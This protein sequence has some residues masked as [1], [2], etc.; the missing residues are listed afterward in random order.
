ML[1]STVVSVGVALTVGLLPQFT[2]QAVAED[3][4]LSRPATQ[5]SLDDPVDGKN[6][7]ARKWDRND[8][9]E[10]AKVTKADRVNWPKAGK[11]DL[12]L[13]GKPVQAEGLPVKVAKADRTSK[14]G[15]NGSTPSSVE[16]EVLG[17]EKAEKAH[18]DGTL[19][20]VGRSDGSGEA[21]PVK[22]T[23]D[24]SSFADAYGGS[25]GSRLRLVEYPE[26]VLTTPDKKK[27]STPKPL[28]TDNDAEDRT[29]TAVV[30]A[31]A[32]TTGEKEDA[33]AQPRTLSQKSNATG[34][35]FTV[36]AA[37]AGESGG[38]GDYKATSLQ[39]S[40]QWSVSNSSGAFNWSYPITAPPVPGGLA[41][42]VSFGYGSQ[43]IDGQTA[44]TNNQGSWVGQGFSYEPGYIERRYK[45]CSE[46]GHAETNGD[47]CWA[48][49]NAT[50][51][52]AGGA[53]GELIKDDTTG[54]WRVSSD[55]FSKVERLTGATNGDNNGEYWKITAVNGTQYFFGLNQLPGFASG[56]TET[57]S[58]WTV[59]VY[60]DDSGE[61]CYDANLADAHCRQAWR[62]NLDYVVD[63]NGS[64][65]AYY[66]GKETNYYTQGLK[67]DENGKAYTRGGY[68][69]RI[70]YGLR[71]DS[72]YDTQPSARIVFTAAERCIGDLTDCG[73]DELTDSTAADWPDVPWDRNC[74]VDTKCPGQNSPTFWTRKKLTKITTQVRD[75]ATTFK[76]V[77]SWTLGHVFSD[78]G[79]GSKSLW[80]NKIVHTGH[81][82]SDETVP[83]IELGGIQL[84]NRIDKTGDNIQP[85]NRFRLNSVVSESGSHLTVNYAD[86]QCSEKN[87]PAAERSTVR[88][89]PVKWN[90]PGEDDPITDWFHKYVVSQVI[91]TDLV[92]GS[93]KQ[94]SS[95]TYLG[96]AG[97]RKAKDD[98]LSK[99]EY[100]TW[101]DWR[102]YQR[103]RVEK[104]DGT[105]K[106]SNT[107]TE[108][109]FF[110]GLDGDKNPDGTE[111][112]STL[113][114]S[115]GQTYTDSDW[116][117]GF[118]AET[119]TYNGSTVVSKS[120]T[121]AWNKVTATRAKSWGTR[122][123][124]FLK[125]LRTDTYTALPGG[126]WR[127]TASTTTYD[128]K[129]G[130]VT[131]VADH[132]ELGVADN[133]CTT[134]EYA[135]NPDKHMYSFVARVEVLGVG[136]DTTPDRS[137]QVI[138]DD[139]TLY[140]GTTDVGAAP[141]KGHPTTIK[142]LASH[143]GSAAT[144]QTVTQAT[145]DTY[146]RPLTVKDAAGTT[147]TTTYTETNGLAT[148]KTDKNP[149]GWETTT[150]Y[151]PEWGSPTG[152]VDP[153]GKRTDLAYD[154]FGR[155]TSVWLPDRPK[156][157]Y[158][159][160]IK[161]SYGIRRDGPNYVHTEKV[162][163]DGKSY[164]SEY[165][166]YDGLL[167][168]RQIQTEGAGGNR[169]IAD[170]LYDGVGRT[171]TTN[172]TYA[173]T[174]APSTDLFLPE[175]KDL[176]AQTVTVYDGAGRTTA[177][178]LNVAGAEKYRTTYA[179]EGDRVH[180]DPPTGQTPTT[181]IVDAH[182]R[183]VELRQYDKSTSP[184]PTG[185]ETDYL[186]TTYTY[187]PSGQLSVVKDD[188][189]NTWSY[190]YDQRGR[191]KEA[192][193][194]DTGKSTFEYDA[195]DRMTSVKDSRGKTT[196][197]TYDAIGRKTGTWDGPAE[198]GT[199][200]SV[201]KWDS[202]AKGHL[203]AEYTYKNNAVYSS[204]LY[205]ALD[206]TYQ[207][208]LVKYNLS[209]TAEPKLGGA[210][211]FTTQYNAD[212]SV[213]SQSFPAT[214][215]LSAETIRYQYD[216]I[217]RPV[218]LTTSLSGGSY[219]TGTTYSPTSQLEQMQLSL[220]GTNKKTWLSYEYEQGTDRLTRSSVIVEGAT[221]AA[222]EGAYTYDQAGNVRSIVD[223]P[224]GGT[225]D[226]QC[227]THD[228][229]RQ[230]TSAWT[231]KVTPD[232]KVGT[233]APDAACAAEPSASN[234]GGTAAYWS[235]YTYDSIGNRKTQ[236]RHGL[237]G[238]PTRET[239]YVYGED[240]AGP[241]QLTTAVTKTA[242][243]STTPEVVS[244]NTYDYDT[245]G[246]TTHR[247]LDGDTQTLTW[248]NQGDLTTVKEANGSETAYVYDSAGS[249]IVRETPT[250]K[251]FYLPGMELKLTKSS[252]TVEAQRFYSF[253]GQ[254]IA[255][256]DKSGVTFL[257][258]DH[259]GT[260]QIAVKA[261]TGET[262]RRR[263][264]PF[265]EN[266]DQ[267][268]TGQS[269]WPTD[270]GFV[271]GTNDKTTG[272]VHLG[273][274]EYDATTGR[275]ISADP[276]IDYT[277]PQQVNGY[278]YSYNNP[279]TFSDPDGLKPDDC[280]H[281]GVQCSLNSK[282]GWDVK[283]TSTYYTYYGYQAPSETAADY[284]A[285]KAAREAELAKQRAIAAAKEIAAIAADELGLTAALDCFTTGALG[286]CGEVAFSVIT[287]LVGG[288]VGKL[289]AK[290][291][292]PW[293][294]A[295]GFAL[296]KRL[297]NLA[298]DLWE[299]V[300]GWWKNSGLAGKATGC[301]APNSFTPS[302]RVLMADGATK[303][304]KDVRIGD[305]VIARDPETGE[306]SVQTVTAEIK[307]E[308]LKR[309]V[310]I[311]ID[312]DGEAG[313]KTAKVTATDGH[314]FWVPE[315]RAWVD[316]TDLESG[317]WLET[318]AGTRVQVTAVKRSSV[319]S[320]TVYNLTVSSAHTYY[321][322]AGATPVLVHNT[323]GSGHMCDI[324]ATA[325]DGSTRVDVK[326]ESGDMT[327]E[328]AAL[329]YPNNSAFTHTEHRFSRM[330][331]ASTGPKV[332]LPNDPFAGKYPLSPGDAVT[333]QGQLPPC[334]RCK[335]AMN[336]MVRELGVTVTYTWDG[337]K[338][339]GTWKARG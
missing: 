237:S 309:L 125:P 307:G 304:I 120:T 7:K 332:S 66:W 69:K 191:K 17:R 46:D 51:S 151:A 34:A 213:Q 201:T 65:M 262:Q 257:A 28:R 150:Y 318:S 130:R 189:G 179:H 311:T 146:G 108:Q 330:A 83:T 103:V 252:G 144:Y 227:F 157:N 186:S 299:G 13:G 159:P 35:G 320:A 2:P 45:G 118:E 198:T 9:A 246:N 53:S 327:P 153:N 76:N 325:P 245:S 73:T 337:A 59:P 256:R 314:P 10:K 230:M 106:P 154:A 336:R 266:R 52:L 123:A 338:G 235:S 200:L 192:V 207:P 143:D 283:V 92:G 132:G 301:L 216:D 111:K 19:L 119:I 64:A 195:L 319:T 142:R 199:K 47:Q 155:L 183:V 82:G 248:N 89:Y 145:Y 228:G 85:F 176:D 26:C 297:W 180:V 326:L 260:A 306:T 331:G 135:D 279:V 231:S 242:A 126:G 243:T 90:P 171:V 87:L 138:S 209:T 270:K 324:T 280:I 25:Y 220:G 247:V 122:Y 88:C 187:T 11:A 289:A 268:S 221:A 136:C 39:P 170:T 80:L 233:G 249:R 8:P 211:E 160:S 105:N 281:N 32:D 96:D 33:G 166:L 78:N 94:V 56:D 298:D 37:T 296:G 30:S 129:T 190:A 128:D 174:G 214:G 238:A 263:L 97:W 93:P 137:K 203:Y 139:L 169:L 168:P 232:R 333:M 23:V 112:S 219:V 16:V 272:L 273:A 60:G 313:T 293:N 208:T 99:D 185:T 335:G 328:E 291:A 67:T 36:L 140:D 40:S 71:D 1:R 202:I 225:T 29:L 48:Y 241:H 177:E 253:G 234:V 278:A 316:A 116:L 167:R 18:I 14:A 38:Q 95:Y 339:A 254:T 117:S 317:N 149:F 100:R 223:T 173:V 44:T 152:Q 322:L 182:D 55:D 305:K 54:E 244:Q 212:G 134:N 161:Y 269:A 217:Q 12:E 91:E 224:T 79:D 196:T 31:A 287:S 261:L 193:D 295:K 251:T 239:S 148:A 86:T 222:Y 229:L 204:V 163:K 310:M 101:S 77:D 265:G 70:E 72:V 321:V 41:P 20:T 181:K 21:G 68:L 175:G 61:P 5:T 109:L 84:P 264:D 275:F 164:G 303:A 205:A 156:A 57:E 210:Y 165:T 290:Y 274:R 102:G 127:Q 255:V 329:G 258:S 3:G 286:S 131:Q 115:T 113:T 271:G 277:D 236:T 141:T 63:P 6:A 215:G 81:V 158:T 276:I 285:R 22:I 206:E 147:T 107:R 288:I 300:K 315:L 323:G 162:E 312:V 62:W 4:G 42:S 218:G 24:Y 43:S 267:T 27:C 184:V 58:A 110:Q 15:K 294:W 49:G 284:K 114:T 188:A 308:G 133:K 302:T 334:S 250:D 124:R 172:D 240:G 178:I 75:G 194:P 50:I 98:G 104:S 292:P 197:T 282:G 259:H 121:T 226:A 74:K